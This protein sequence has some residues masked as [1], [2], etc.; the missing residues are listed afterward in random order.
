MEDLKRKRIYLVA[1][2]VGSLF[3]LCS[4]KFGDD[5]PT[6]PSQNR[7]VASREHFY[8]FL[9]SHIDLTHLSGRAVLA[10]SS[11]DDPNGLRG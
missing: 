4:P 7:D 10:E 3:W 11:D 6:A 8:P 1:Q 5:F 9:G 2:I